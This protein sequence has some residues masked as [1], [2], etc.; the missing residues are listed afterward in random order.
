MV[1][2][3]MVGFQSRGCCVGCGSNKI[4]SEVNV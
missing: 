4:Y 1:M 2:V 3:V